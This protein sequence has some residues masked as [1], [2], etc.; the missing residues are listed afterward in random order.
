MPVMIVHHRVRDYVTWRPFYDAHEGA[1]AAATITSG[2]VFRGADDPNDIIILFEVA[3]L[4]KA[5]AFAASEDLKST[6]NRA[7]V[8]GAPAIHVMG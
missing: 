8:I 6:M 7:G 5:Q 3:D 2:K 4:A 1:R